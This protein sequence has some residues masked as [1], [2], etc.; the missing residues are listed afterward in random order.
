MKHTKALGLTLALLLA[1]GVTPALAAVSHGQNVTNDAIFGAGNA[2]GS[3]TVDRQNGVE[4]GL[5]AKVRFPVPANTFNDNGDGTFSHLA[6]NDAGRPLWTMEWSVNSDWDGSSGWMLD[7]LTYELGMDFDPSPGTSF[8]AWDHITVGGFIP[9][10]PAV[11]PVPGYD[12]SIGTNATGNGAG[13]EAAGPLFVAYPGLVAANNLAQN[14][15]RMDF[16]DEFPFTFDPDADGV[17][18]FYLKAFHNGGEVASVSIQVLVGDVGACCTNGPMTDSDCVHDS[19]AGCDAGG[20][21]YSGDTTRCSVITENTDCTT[22][23]VEFES[24]SATA[25]PAG[26]L[27]EWTTA[28]EVDTVGFRILR[29]TRGKGKG[30]EKAITVVADRIPASGNGLSGASYEFLDNSRIRGGAEVVYYLEDLDAFGRVTR[31]GPIQVQRGSRV[32]QSSGR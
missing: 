2:N 25:T 17:Y 22:L 29:E 19:Q 14:S 4:L 5:R 11:G 21:L 6:G 16:F 1:I 32:R 8:L 24:L 28:V 27:L 7:D 13:V 3:F 18:D 15:W 26:V 23:L 20:G 9:F 30:A 10:I 31:H 12:H